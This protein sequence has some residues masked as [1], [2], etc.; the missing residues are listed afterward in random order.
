MKNRVFGSLV[1]IA[2]VKKIGQKRSLKLYLQLHVKGGNQLD[3]CLGSYS[4]ALT[5]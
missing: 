4:L 3:N 2:E 1:A 5:F